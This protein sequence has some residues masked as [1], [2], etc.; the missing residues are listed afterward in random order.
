MLSIDLGLGDK[1]V[2]LRATDRLDDKPDP[3][4]YFKLLLTLHLLKIN[5]TKIRE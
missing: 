2:N 4:A 5:N 3:L 1:V